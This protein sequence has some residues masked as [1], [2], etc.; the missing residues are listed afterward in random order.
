MSAPKDYIRDFI[1]EIR[2]SS[3]LNY[4]FRFTFKE[5]L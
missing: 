2:L 5:N 1:S 4:I 3:Y